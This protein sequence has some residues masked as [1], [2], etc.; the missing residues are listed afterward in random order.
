MAEYGELLRAWRERRGLS[1]RALAAALGVNSGIISRLEN[2]PRPPVRYDQ[3]LRISAL[4][5]LS[6][7]ERDALLVAGGESPPWLRGAPLDDPDL[8][9][10]V[11]LLT[12]PALSPADCQEFRLGFR[13]LARRWRPSLGLSLPDRLLPDRQ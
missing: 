6:E 1:Q 9:A 3:T 5:G 4:L 2:D 10:F 13:I 11:S 7:E 12:D 8:R